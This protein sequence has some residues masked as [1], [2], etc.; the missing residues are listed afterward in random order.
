MSILFLQK[1]NSKLSSNLILF[2]KHSKS[3]KA[4]S[5]CEKVKKDYINHLATVHDMIE[6]YFKVKGV[7]LDGV[8]RM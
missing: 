8:S 1:N 4:Y 6:D 5:L 2:Q 3:Y 7:N